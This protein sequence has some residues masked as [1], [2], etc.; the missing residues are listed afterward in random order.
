MKIETSKQ[1]DEFF[2]TTAYWPG[3]YS[4]F[5]IDVTDSEC[6]CHSCATRQKPDLDDKFKSGHELHEQSGGDYD[7]NEV[8]CTECFCDLSDYGE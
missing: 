8:H 5:L 6:F 3:L 7:P 2:K 4:K 1:L